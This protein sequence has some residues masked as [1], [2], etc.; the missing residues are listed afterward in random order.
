MKYLIAY[1]LYGFVFS[2]FCHNE[3]DQSI[4]WNPLQL[5]AIILLWPVVLLWAWAHVRV[6]RW[7]GKEVWRRK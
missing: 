2:I 5:I 7:K 4:W 6:I 3:K 1:I